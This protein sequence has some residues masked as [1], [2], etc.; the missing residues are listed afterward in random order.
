MR[1]QDGFDFSA[2]LY[3]QE[4]CTG[5]CPRCPRLS[6]PGGKMTQLVAEYRLFVYVVRFCSAYSPCSYAA[7]FC[8]QASP[9][10][11]S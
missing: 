7:A 2:L 8:K 11:A 3:G 6:E 9:A 4:F 1:V 10:S 5:S